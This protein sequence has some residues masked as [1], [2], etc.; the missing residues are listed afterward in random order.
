LVFGLLLH[1]FGGAQQLK[2]LQERNKEVYIM[3]GR[4]EKELKAEEKMNKKLNDLPKVFTEFYY[5]MA[6]DGKSYTTMQKYIS[7]NVDFMNYITKGKYD[8]KFYECIRT[9]HVNQYMASIRRKTINGSVVRNGDDICAARWTSLRA[10]FNFLKENEY[11]EDNPFDKTSRPKIRTEHKVTYLTQNEINLVMSEIKSKATKKQLSRDLCLVSLAL[12]TGLRVSAITQIN[13]EDIDFKKRTINVIE[14]GNK[15]RTIQFGENLEILLKQCIID[16]DRYFSGAETNALFLSQWRRRMTPEAVRNL[17]QKYTAVIPDKHISPHKFR[18]SA[19]TNLAAS[20][21][22]IQAIAKVL[23]HE[24][25]QT[26]RRYVEVLD[27]EAAKA[28]NILDN[29]I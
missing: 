13:I 5:S 20:G 17:T 2:M 21:V 7:H 24:N 3:N 6:A 8:E 18:A 22:S 25:I 23:G 19:A 11:I 16:R 28:T 14:K 9:P 15:I 12:S 26:T 4:L 27:S 29:L 10:F 1:G